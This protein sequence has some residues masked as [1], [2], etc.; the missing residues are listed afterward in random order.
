MLLG[1]SNEL[2]LHMTSYCDG[3]SLL[4]LAQTCRTLRSLCDDVSVVKGAFFRR[5]SDGQRAIPRDVLKK[6]IGNDRRILARHLVALGCADDLVS[7]ALNGILFDTRRSLHVN[8]DKPTLTA[9]RYLPH[10]LVTGCK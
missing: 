4:S 5:A 9:C 6:W 1:L 2:L 10:L 7:D 3:K 8:E